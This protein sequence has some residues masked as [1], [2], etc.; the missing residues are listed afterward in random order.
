MPGPFSL[1]LD[2]D[3][4]APFTY[5]KT[6]HMTYIVVFW[7]TSIL[8]SIHEVKN[9]KIDFLEAWTI[10]FDFRFGFLGLF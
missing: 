9:S 6:P 1:T 2:L 10:Q 7:L 3:F 5:K 8:T 4:S